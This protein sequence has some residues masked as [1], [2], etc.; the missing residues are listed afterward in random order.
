MIDNFR[1]N[2][3]LTI[4]LILDAQSGNFPFDHELI[5]SEKKRVIQA[6]DWFE[7]HVWY[8]KGLQP[9]FEHESGK[10]EMAIG[11]IQLEVFIIGGAILFVIKRDEQQVT[12]KTSDN[13]HQLGVMGLGDIEATADNAVDMIYT[14]GNYI[15]AHGHSFVFNPKWPG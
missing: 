15:T 3:L 9:Y 1:K 4:P 5:I 10:H 12:L 11:T 14:A 7:E 2:R 6:I 8:G 13:E